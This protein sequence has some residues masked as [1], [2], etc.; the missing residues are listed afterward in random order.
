VTVGLAATVAGGAVWKLVHAV[1][2]ARWLFAA[3]L[4]A[5]LLLMVAVS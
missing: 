1:P 5:G 2:R 3:G 4:A